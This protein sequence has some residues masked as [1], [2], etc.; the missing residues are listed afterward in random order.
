MNGTYLIS[1]FLEAVS[2]DF[3]SA[4]FENMVLL[5]KR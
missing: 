2:G 5:C 3:C 4:A 1:A